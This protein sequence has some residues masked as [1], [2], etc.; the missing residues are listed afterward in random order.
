MACGAA[1]IPALQFP[2][3]EIIEIIPA[4]YNNGSK[5]IH[6]PNL[7]EKLVPAS[8]EGLHMPA[9]PSGQISPL[10]GMGTPAGERTPGTMTPEAA[11]RES[12][13]LPLRK[14]MITSSP[15]V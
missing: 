8:P 14:S 7:S 13:L 6:I 12:G 9:P 5:R 1:D 11:G 15:R 10:S 4:S 3:D 2:R